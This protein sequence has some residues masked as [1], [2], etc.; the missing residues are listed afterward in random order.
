[1]RGY[2]TS[3]PCDG[4]TALT[5]VPCCPHRGGSQLGAGSASQIPS[6]ARKCFLMCNLRFTPCSTWTGP[7]WP[8]SLSCP[9]TAALSP[10]CSRSSAAPAGRGMVPCLTPIPSGGSPSREPAHPPHLPHQQDWHHLVMAP[11]GG[12]SL[13]SWPAQGWQCH[14]S[15]HTPHAASEPRCHPLDVQDCCGINPRGIWLPGQGVLGWGVWLLLRAEE[16]LCL[17][18][19]CCREQ[20]GDFFFF[21]LFYFFEALCVLHQPESVM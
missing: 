2:R 4:H 6:R 1:M 12:K 18:S 20:Q 13:L 17:F 15:S 19:I 21:L 8:H 3:Q 16:Q 5:G 10:Q 11:W 9:H 14:L 7:W